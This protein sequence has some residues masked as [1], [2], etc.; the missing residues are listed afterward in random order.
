MNTTTTEY[1]STTTVARITRQTDGVERVRVFANGEPVADFRSRA[2]MREW[3][4]AVLDRR[5]TL[6]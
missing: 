1:L 5:V 2:A 3:W 6:S 4:A